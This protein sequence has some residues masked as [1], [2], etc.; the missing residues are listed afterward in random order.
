MI[1]NY[2][3]LIVGSGAGGAALAYALADSGASI[4]VLEKGKELP[5]DGSTL[6]VNEVFVNGRFKSKERWLDRHDREFTPE[7]YFNLGGKTMWYGAA[8][9]RFAEQEFAADPAHGCHNWPFRREQLEPY[10]ERAEAL[11]GVRTFA[12]EPDLRSLLDRLKRRDQGWR[13]LS[14]PLALEPEILEQEVEAKHFDGFASVRGSKGDAQ[15]KIWDRLAYR[16]NVTV[17]SGKAVEQLLPGARAQAISGV[18]CEDGSEFRARRVI[19]AAGALHSP[20]LIQRYLESFPEA[21]P[22]ERGQWIGRYA[23][24]HLNTAMLVLG[25]N[26]RTDLL[27][28]TVLLFHQRFPHSS[29]QTLGW[30]DGEIVGAQLP[31]LLPRALANALANLLGARAYGFWITTED[32]SHAENRVIAE[33]ADSPPRL[34]FDRNRLPAAEREHRALLRHLSLQFAGMGLAPFVKRMPLAATAHACGTLVTGNDPAASVVDANGLM[35]G[36]ENLYVADGSVLPRSSRVN[37]ALTIYAWGLR[38]ADHLLAIEKKGSAPQE[39][40]A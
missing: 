26:R 30:M 37:P 39:I 11:L 27:R 9:I 1:A 35:H 10:Y 33:R 5:W 16:D 34:D 4:L 13:E 28:K 36:M 20:R 14:L 32:G 19:L 29:V 7:E 6:E 38:L 18:R 40:N 17:M 24:F 8:L 22:P 25:P 2:D 21:M 23:K 3:Y 15:R 31:S 12:I